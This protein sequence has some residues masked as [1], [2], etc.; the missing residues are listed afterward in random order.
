MIGR[1]K[2]HLLE[3]Q[4]PHLMVDVN[5]VGYCLQAP[6]STFFNLPELGKEVTLYT[7]MIVREDAQLLF[8]FSN[9]QESQLFQEVIKVN[10]VGPKVALAIL[11][12]LSP[13]EFIE[14]VCRHDIAT[15]QR[16]PGIGAKTAQRII[17]ELEDRLS[18]FSE[19]AM[20]V[21][22]AAMPF[23]ESA[24]DEAISALIALGYKPHEATKAVAKV[25]NTTQGCEYIIK[26]ALQGLAKV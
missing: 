25:K 20:M 3:K 26:E 15:L 13:H 10:G 16:L 24:L 23:M 8:G 21:T 12:G 6:L 5:G 4:P 14:V 9:K 7:H 17:V 22:K 11:S 2:G 1:L 19:K 18:K